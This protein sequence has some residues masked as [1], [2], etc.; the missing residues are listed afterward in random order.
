MDGST[1]AW[2]SFSG[3]NACGFVPV[4]D[5]FELA[6]QDYPDGPFQEIRFASPPIEIPTPLGER[7]VEEAP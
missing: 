6:K 7:R 5:S 3:G 2:I 4:Y 1:L